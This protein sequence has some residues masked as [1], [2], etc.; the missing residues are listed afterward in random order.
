MVSPW[1]KGSGFYYENDAALAAIEASIAARFRL[2]RDGVQ[3][4]R[5]ML[6]ELAAADQSVRAIKAESKRPGLGRT[7]REALRRSED[8]KKRLAEA[9]RRF[10]SLKVG[11]IPQ[12]K[13]AW[14]GAH[15]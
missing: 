4:G 13:L 14:R 3:A 9:E 11:L 15:R 1:N 6:H 2:L 7:Q 12:L 5:E 10:K 8:Y